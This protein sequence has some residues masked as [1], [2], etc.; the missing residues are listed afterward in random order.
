MSPPAGNI[1]D[2]Y[3]DDT[4]DDDYEDQPVLTII[5]SPGTPEER[6]IPGVPTCNMTDEEVEKMEID[7]STGERRAK[8]TTSI[9]DYDITDTFVVS[10]PTTDHAVDHGV[11][12]RL[13]Y[14]RSDAKAWVMRT[15]GPVFETFVYP[16]RWGFRVY[17]PTAK[18]GRYTPPERAL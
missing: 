15:Y 16:H 10:G 11:R 8:R 13:F 12:G 4:R 6:A 1:F 14:E 7:Y 3:P 17:K 2:P 5:E 18:K 9:A